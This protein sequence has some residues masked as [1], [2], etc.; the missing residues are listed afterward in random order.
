MKRKIILY[1][2]VLALLS[3]CSAKIGDDKGSGPTPDDQQKWASSKQ[4]ITGVNIDGDWTTSCISFKYSSGSK[5]LDISFTNG[6]VK[7]EYNEYSDEHCTQPSYTENYQGQFRFID[8]FDDSTYS[9]EYRLDVGNNIT[10]FPIE[11]IQLTNNLLYTS[12]FNGDDAAPV[13]L[14][15]PLIKKSELKQTN[16]CENFAGEF[17]MNSDHFT[18]EQ[19]KCL[20]LKFSID[21]YPRSDKV[22]TYITDGMPRQVEGSLI[23]KPQKA[24]FKDKLFVIEFVSDKGNHTVHEYS[25]KTKPCDLMNPSGEQ[26]LERKIFIDG[27]EQKHQCDFW[28]RY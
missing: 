24:Y 8:K 17:Q 26:F 20:A 16:N 25:Y 12:L 5:K 14:D 6:D 9:V 18:I 19:N 13:V 23:C 3:A 4:T 11:K 7:R 10:Y 21:D 15:M 28:A 22:L 27:I 1:A 2:G